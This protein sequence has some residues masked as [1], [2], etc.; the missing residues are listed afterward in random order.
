MNSSQTIPLSP[1]D[2]VFVGRDSYSVE[3]MLA[4]DYRLDASLLLRALE[5]TVRVFW[6]VRADLVLTS[7]RSYQFV[8][9]G[10]A[11]DFAV[12][13]DSPIL[14]NF[15]VP[16]ELARLTEPVHTI[17]GEPL[18]KFRL[19]YFGRKSIFV[20]NISHALVDG[21][22][23]FFF[24]SMVAANYRNQPWQL[25][26]WQTKFMK[27]DLDRRKLCLNQ[28]R[29]A[30]PINLVPVQRE[31]FFRRSGFS[32]AGR[33]H[34]PSL[35]Q[36]RWEFIRF[37][38]SQLAGYLEKSQHDR[39]SKHDI[40]TA[41]LWQRIARDW[42]SKNES[43]ECSSAFDYRRVHGGLS[44]RYWGNAVRGTAAKMERDEILSLEV[45]S[46]ATKIRQATRAIDRAAVLDSLKFL[47]D[48][49]LAH[50]PD[51]FLNAHVSHPKEGLLVTN[52]SRID[53]GRLDFGEGAPTQVIPLTAAPRAA[54]L[55]SDGED[56]VARLGLPL[57]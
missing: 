11:L 51:V 1:I 23:Y 49:R 29:S 35:T 7:D 20:A 25:A 38:P 42:H 22:S 24:L 37:T 14:P 15:E 44:P 26:Y 33:R 31:E 18:A 17:P 48:T 4:F 2:H 21:Y 43:L 34:L 9:Q 27:P 39:L 46:L 50:G 52:L 6:P 19:S 16:H 36:S 12:K 55:L 54:I 32:Y 45:T 47:D 8:D 5:Q 41:M 30:T 13:E 56:I 53:R 57:E 40:I 28:S 10:R 3:F